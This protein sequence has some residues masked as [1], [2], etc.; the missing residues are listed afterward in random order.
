[1]IHSA[2]LGE[3]HR[4]DLLRG[5]GL[6][7]LQIL[8]LDHRIAALIDD[9]ERPGLDILLDCGVVESSADEAPGDSI[10]TEALT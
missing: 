6:G 10:S 8:D 7:L 9:L 4:R 2:H 1:M 5:E 3:N